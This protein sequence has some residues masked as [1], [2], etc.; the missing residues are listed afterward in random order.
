MGPLTISQAF[1]LQRADMSLHWSFACGAGLS[2][3]KE[4]SSAPQLWRRIDT[5]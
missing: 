5:V 4:Q 1:Q 2:V 3:S